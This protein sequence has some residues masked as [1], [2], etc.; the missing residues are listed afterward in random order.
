MLV[1]FSVDRKE[2]KRKKKPQRTL[3]LI[4]RKKERRR[5][6]RA[7]P[8]DPDAH[9]QAEV[10][11][12][13]TLTLTEGKRNSPGTGMA[14]VA[15]KGVQPLS[16]LTAVRPPAG[17]R[18]RRQGGQRGAVAPFLCG[19]EESGK[20]GETVCSPPLRWA[21]SSLPA[22]CRQRTPSPLANAGHGFCSPPPV[23]VGDSSGAEKSE[24]GL[25]FWAPGPV[26]GFVRATV[27]DD[28]RMASDG[29]G[30]Q[31]GHPTVGRGMTWLASV[32]RAAEQRADRRPWAMLHGPQS[33][34]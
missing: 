4:K 32:F 23:R 30:H 14:T 27:A 16:R 10:S 15:G 7:V 6:G 17:G 9:R 2:P 12:R 1:L 22:C 34:V 19:E 21:A 5:N 8:L 31:R 3:T 33:G 18:T 26:R 24:M 11:G 28:R 29:Q 13:R 20:E 25:G